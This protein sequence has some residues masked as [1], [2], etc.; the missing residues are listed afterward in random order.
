M[1]QSDPVLSETAPQTSTLQAVAS[2]DTGP[3]QALVDAMLA[4]WKPAVRDVEPGPQIARYTARRVALS[5]RFP[6]DALVVATG[7]EKVRANDTAYRFRPGSDF[8]YLT[9]N[10]EPDCALILMPRAGGGHDATLFVEPNPGTSDATFFT[11]RVKGELWV[12]PRL[13]VPESA[14]RFGIATRPLGELAAT[15]G[16]L[17]GPSSP[18]R[19]VRRGDDPR[20]DGALPADAGLD[21]E[22]ATVLSELRLIK[23]AYEIAELE[24]AIAA[25][26]R[27]FEDVLA[28]L[29]ASRTERF[30]EGVFG[31]R[32]RIDGND[33]GYNSVAASGA[34][35]CT[36]HWTRNDGPLR[37]GEL[38]LLDA[39]VE[40]DTLYTADVTRTIPISGRFSAEQREVYELVLA[41]QDAGFAAC[42]PGA[43]FLAPHRAA[44]SVLA[45]GLER[46]GILAS[47]EVALQPDRQLYKRYT[48]H[49]TSHMLGLDVH[50]CALAREETYRGGTLAAGMVLTIEP[51]CY[52][53]P[54]DLTVPERYRGIGVRIEDDVLVTAEGCRNL[55]AALPRAVD[56]VERWVIACSERGYRLPHDHRLD[57]P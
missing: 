40:A 38:L 50:D 21:A 8:Y 18:P 14:R 25:T 28:A 26:A 24:G 15:L 12:G 13:G 30:V 37:P 57:A 7:G 45:H 41:A 31:L 3:P 49:G 1:S 33:V 2:H 35:A 9:G 11:D 46:M 5:E 36:L 20:V 56:D 19:R 47:A 48:L 44:M 54:N 39:G 17:A 22:F 29:P 6:G 34:H 43:D 32:A 27:G 16:A 53:Q 52:F 42:A 55:S 23:D 51:G 10:V 4:N